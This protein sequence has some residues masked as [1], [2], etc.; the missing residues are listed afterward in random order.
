VVRNDRLK[1]RRLTTELNL[2]H[3]D[4][5][6]GGGKPEARHLVSRVVRGGLTIN[7][8]GR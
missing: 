6:R 1:D 2:A 3:I 7:T 8:A 4:Q 5:G